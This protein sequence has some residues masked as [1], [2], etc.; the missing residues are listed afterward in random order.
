[1]KAVAAQFEQVK[2]L[3]RHQNWLNGP[4]TTFSF[5]TPGR[6]SREVTVYGATELRST[7]PVV[8]VL[9][10]PDDWGSLIGLRDLETGAIACKSEA[11]ARRSVACASVFIVALLVSWIAGISFG[12][13]IG[14]FVIVSFSLWQALREFSDTKNVR[15]ILVSFERGEA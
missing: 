9:R 6:Q 7:M 12:M 10:D 5:A 4:S 15:H 2:V 14:A 3:K 1:M 8:A 11:H 13:L